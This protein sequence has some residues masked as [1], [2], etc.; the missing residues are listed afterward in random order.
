KLPMSFPRAVGQEP[1]Y[2]SEFPTGR[3]PFGADLSKP[4]G[5]DTRFISRYIDVPND[6]LF[7]FGYGLSYTKFAYSGVTLSRTSVPLDEARQ[8]A[9]EKLITATAT[10]KNVGGRTGA[11][12]VECYI[13]DLGTSLEQPVRR[14]SGFARIT[15]KPGESRTVSFN[16]G[17]PELSFYTNAGKA[18]IE[19]SHYTVWIGGSSLA[20]RHAEFDITPQ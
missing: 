12:V 5:P 19:P 18:T 4:P 11:E 2:Y 20:A 13:R 8:N 14:L 7:P 10:V 3:P 6:A 9:A 15:L 17:F 16:L 1:L